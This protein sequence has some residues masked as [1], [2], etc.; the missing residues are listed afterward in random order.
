MTPTATMQSRRST[1][2]KLRKQVAPRAGDVRHRLL[3]PL[4][5][6]IGEDSVKA[7]P[8]G[9][10]RPPGQK[11][12]TGACRGLLKEN[13]AR[14]SMVD[15]SACNGLRDPQSTFRY[16]SIRSRRQ[17]APSEP[18]SSAYTSQSRGVAP[19]AW[20]STS[21]RALIV[22]SSHL[23]GMTGISRLDG[24]SGVQAMVALPRVL[25]S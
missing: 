19:A 8:V 10:P 13:L 6:D 7:C 5:P 25:G 17:G 2:P 20:P 22:R 16:R 15:R 14:S 9:D 11:A 23:L 4:D 24:W 18:S 12:T 1:D 21:D 3:P